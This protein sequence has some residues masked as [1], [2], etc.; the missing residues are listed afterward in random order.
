MRGSSPCP[1]ASARRISEPCCHWDGLPSCCLRA[2]ASRVVNRTVLAMLLQEVKY[3]T[4]EIREFGFKHCSRSQLRILVKKPRPLSGL[5]ELLHLYRVFWMR[6]VTTIWVNKAQ[7][8]P[9]KKKG[10]QLSFLQQNGQ[11]L[12]VKRKIT[13]SSVA[14]KNVR[15]SRG[16]GGKRF[17]QAGEIAELTKIQMGMISNG[18]SQI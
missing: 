2:L 13:C 6:N 8:F 11:V 15:C 5:S 16:T 9:L 7:P 18:N 10:V 12:Y 1:Q 14:E 3:R 4:N 17:K